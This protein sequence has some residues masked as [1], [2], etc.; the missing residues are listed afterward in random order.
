MMI[1]C[2]RVRASGYFSFASTSTGGPRS[3]ATDDTDDVSARGAAATMG[4]GD[5]TTG[6]AATGGGVARLTTTVYC[7]ATQPLAPPWALDRSERTSSAA[8]DAPVTVNRS[9]SLNLA[10]TLADVAGS[11]RKLSGAPSVLATRSTLSAGGSAVCAATSV[12]D[13]AR[14]TTNSGTP[15]AR[16]STEI[17]QLAPSPPVIVTPSADQVGGRAEAPIVDNVRALI[18]H[19]RPGARR[20]RHRLRDQ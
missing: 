1:S 13:S 4:S 18:Q 7:D 20:F 8:R 19:N 11:V 6:A 12:A 9:P 14:I 15:T 5:G 3:G 10:T 17:D 2:S 16:A